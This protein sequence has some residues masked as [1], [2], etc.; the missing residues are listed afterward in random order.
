LKE[1]KEIFNGFRKSLQVSKSSCAMMMFNVEDLLAL[2]Q[3]KQGK[4]PKTIEPVDLKQALIEVGGILEYQ[5]K[6]KNIHLNFVE[7]GFE[8]T[9]FADFKIL[10]DKQRF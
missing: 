9:R 6:T 8:N 10:F 2:P 7:D 1:T 4:L 3:L 5:L